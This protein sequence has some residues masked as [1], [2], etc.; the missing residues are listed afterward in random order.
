MHLFAAPVPAGKKALEHET[1][2]R[3]LAYAVQEVY[4]LSLPEI[5]CDS[6]GKPFFPQRQE[7]CFNLSHCRGLAVCGISAFPLGVDCESIRSLRE[8][9][10][11]RSFAPEEVLANHGKP[12]PDKTFPVLDAERSVCRK[13]LG[14]ASLPPLTRQCLRWT[15][16][17]SSPPQGWQFRQFRLD[18][19]HVVS[20][21]GA[22]EDTLPEELPRCVI[23]RK[24]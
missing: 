18:S 3:L 2:Y 5:A 9:V 20:C 16:E 1:A 23:L 14:V 15:G 22:S 11:R 21:C 4:G 24:H 17:M 10:L 13:A 19:G 7:I 8:G 12:Q 6:R